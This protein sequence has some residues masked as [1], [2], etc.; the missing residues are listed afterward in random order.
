MKPSIFVSISSQIQMDKNTR[1]VRNLDINPCI[2]VSLPIT[3]ILPCLKALEGDGVYNCFVGTF[4]LVRKLMHH[5]NVWIQ[6]TMIRVCVQPISK[7]TRTVESTGWVYSTFVVC[8]FI[9][10]FTNDEGLMEKRHVH[11]LRAR[12]WFLVASWGLRLLMKQGHL[13]VGLGAC[14]RGAK[15]VKGSSN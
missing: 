11:H 7:G 6:T 15:A 5:R 2:E 8:M 12:Q 13:L 1:K 14:T 9:Q 3:H 4:S 10:F